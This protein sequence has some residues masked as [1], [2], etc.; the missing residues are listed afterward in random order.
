MSDFNELLW[1]ATKFDLV[2]IKDAVEL[3]LIETNNVY[4]EFKFDEKKLNVLKLADNYGLS[5][6]RR[7]LLRKENTIK[8]SVTR[9]KEFLN[10][11]HSSRFEILKNTFIARYNNNSSLVS[12]SKELGLVELWVVLNCFDLLIHENRT[13]EFGVMKNQATNNIDTT[14]LEQSYEF[15]YPKQCSDEIVLN[16]ENGKKQIYV[17]CF[18]LEQNS[19]VLKEMLKKDSKGEQ[20]KSL[21][22]SQR[23]QFDMIQF[24]SFLKKPKNIKSISFQ[25]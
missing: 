10:L 24:I 17:D 14:I 12:S 2:K 3:F 22:F 16:V 7:G 8:T 20:K 9:T 18:T 19:P 13:T 4:V 6:L 25:L 11:T 21:D 15:L 5:G 1:I 23:S